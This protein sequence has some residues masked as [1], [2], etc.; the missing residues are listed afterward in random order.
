MS[1]GLLFA[2][3]A[4]AAL[5]FAYASWRAAKKRREAFAALVASQGWSW[6]PED[7]R[8]TSHWTG[9]PFD[10][11]DHRRARNVVTGSRDGRPVV[12]SDYSYQTHTTNA[13]GHRQTTTHRY[14]VCG[15]ELPAPLPVL[16]VEHE[17]LLG[18]VANALG[19]GDIELESED[20]NRAFR[21]RCADRKFASDI[22]HPRMMEMLLAGG[23]VAWR[24]HGDSI[25][26][27]DNGQHT[28]SQV[29]ARLALLDAIADRI[30][31]LHLARPWRRSGAREPRGRPTV[32]A[33][34]AAIG[35]V[36]HRCHCVG[37]QLQ[38]VRPAVQPR[39]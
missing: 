32:T 4:L 5:A 36:C 38:P 7:N 19:F 21:V 16:E 15:V 28:P 26:C 6:Y 34:Y 35:G 30:P 1:P 27:W 22:L 18:K 20:F 17:G 37:H 39:A 2:A 29:M 8:W 23:C 24:I 9:A 10:R 31:G 13:Q 33:V 14:G 11:G 12:A 25:M 3:A